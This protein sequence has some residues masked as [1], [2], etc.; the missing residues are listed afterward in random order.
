METQQPAESAKPTA[1][2]TTLDVTEVDPLLESAGKFADDP[3]WDVMMDSIRRHR[4]EI[5]AE[6][7]NVE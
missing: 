4:L 5:D 2:M 3:Y 6:W 7:D 1:Q